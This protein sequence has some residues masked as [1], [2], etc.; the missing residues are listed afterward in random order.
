MYHKQW[1]KVFGIKLEGEYLK[2]DHE[3][4]YS[5]LFSMINCKITNVKPKS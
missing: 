4:H 2:K 3:N 5:V 1:G